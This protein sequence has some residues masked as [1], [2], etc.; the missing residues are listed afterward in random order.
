MIKATPLAPAIKADITRERQTLLND[1][2]QRWNMFT[3]KGLHQLTDRHD[4]VRQVSSMYGVDMLAA[5]K[6][7][8][9]VLKGRT[10]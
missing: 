7:V 4:L 2:G 8:D 3:S 6:E 5:E 1:I 10:L 9:R